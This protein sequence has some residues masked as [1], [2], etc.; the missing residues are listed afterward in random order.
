MTADV[1]V[2][3]RRPAVLTAEDFAVAIPVANAHV[4]RPL[5]W[6]HQ[7]VSGDCSGRHRCRGKIDSWRTSS[8]FPR[9][10]PEDL[11]PSAG[12]SAVAWSA[13]AAFEQLVR[14][15]DPVV[16]DPRF[17]CLCGERGQERESVGVEQ[18]PAISRNPHV[19]TAAG[20]YDVHPP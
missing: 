12:P 19:L 18:G 11:S 8:G 1:S 20:R 9:V 6:E 15:Y 16:G 7:R 13:F 10:M 14:K 2:R 3:L 4:D 5:R 17:Q